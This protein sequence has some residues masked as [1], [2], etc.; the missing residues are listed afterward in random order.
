MLQG[1]DHVVCMIY[2]RIRFLGW[3]CSVQ[4]WTTALNGGLDINDL[5]RDTYVRNV[6]PC[7]PANIVPRWF[8]VVDSSTPWVDAFLKGVDFLWVGWP[9]RVLCGIAGERLPQDD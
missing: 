6:N 1:G 2:S 4:S 5:A 9:C 3:I 7:I 8:Q